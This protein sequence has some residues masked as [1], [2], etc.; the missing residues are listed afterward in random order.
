[1]SLIGAEGTSGSRST[2]RA[3]WIRAA[4]C[5]SHC[6]I[7]RIMFRD[8]LSLL[9][10]H[11]FCLSGS[12]RFSILKTKRGQRAVGFAPPF[13]ALLLQRRRSFIFFYFFTHPPPS[14][15]LGGRSEFIHCPR[16]CRSRASITEDEGSCFL[17][18]I[19]FIKHVLKK[20]KATISTPQT[21]K[22]GRESFYGPVSLLRPHFQTFIFRLGLS[23]A[24]QDEL[25]VKTKKI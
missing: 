21:C 18:E 13:A 16:L 17:S 5:S 7:G 2:L 11:V 15:D 6:V 10:L 12:Q 4:G 24:S 25:F 22:S 19:C 3:V 14:G 9:H 1:M 8:S 23:G 20:E